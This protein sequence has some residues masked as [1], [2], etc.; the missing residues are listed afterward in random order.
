[1][2]EITVDRAALTAAFDDMERKL[3]YAVLAGLDFAARTTATQARASHWYQNRT[4]D[5][6][7]STREQESEGDVWSDGAF[8]SVAATEPYASYVDAR[9]PILEPAW[10]AVSMRVEHDF[11]FRMEE[12][13]R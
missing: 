6:Q 5:L 8:S 11:L 2:I 9:S 4:G 13:C 10:A 7:A 3:E 12:A 1:M